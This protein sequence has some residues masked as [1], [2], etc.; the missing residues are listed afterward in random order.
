MTTTTPVRESVK[1]LA[2]PARAREA[3]GRFTGEPRPVSELAA[4]RAPR[5]VSYGAWYHEAAIAEA[6]KKSR[7]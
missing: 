1:I 6:D 7:S 4:R 3:S 5:V 2:F